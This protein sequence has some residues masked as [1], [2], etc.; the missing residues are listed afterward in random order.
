M[1]LIQILKE[2]GLNTQ[3]ESTLS[4]GEVF[5]IGDDYKTINYDI[6]KLREYVMSGLKSFREQWDKDIGDGSWRE[7][8]FTDEELKGVVMEFDNLSEKWISFL[9]QVVENC[10]MDHGED[11][12]ALKLRIDKQHN[13]FPSYFNDMLNNYNQNDPLD[14]IKLNPGIANTISLG[15]VFWVGDER[16][17]YDEVR[18]EKYVLANIGLLSK[19][20]DEENNDPGS[21]KRE[22]ITIE[23]LKSTIA[24]FNDGEPEWFKVINNLHNEYVEDFGE[25]KKLF[26]LEVDKLHLEFPSYFNDMLNDYIQNTP[27]DEIKLNSPQPYYHKSQWLEDRE[28]WDEES[29]YDECSAAF[30]TGEEWLCNAKT[31][32]FSLLSDMKSSFNREEIRR[33]IHLELYINNPTEKNIDEFIEQLR[34]LGMIK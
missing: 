6:E 18:L 4:L 20:W 33:V 1:K 32:Y 26:K 3:G 28:E 19:V 22:K 12:E 5:Y 34:K 24:S 31:F 2:I 15:D 14:E 30:N 11:L 8:Q 27:L 25:D 23:D 13:K 21:W 17:F 10:V 16:I 9:D 7:A 29:V